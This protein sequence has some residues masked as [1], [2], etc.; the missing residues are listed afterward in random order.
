MSIKVKHKFGRSKV[1]DTVFALE[2]QNLPEI[3]Q[4]DSE[5]LLKSITF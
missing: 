1:K 5:M 3:S 2:N 4:G